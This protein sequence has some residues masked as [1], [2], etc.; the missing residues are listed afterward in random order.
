VRD[1]QARKTEKRSDSVSSEGRGGQN[2]GVGGRAASSATSIPGS[3]GDL[4]GKRGRVKGKLDQYGDTLRKKKWT[5]GGGI[6]K[7]CPR[8]LTD[9][10]VAREKDW[11]G[12]GTKRGR[13]FLMRWDQIG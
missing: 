1:R 7:T 13:D 8:V 12:G 3:G 2:I 6:T 4:R 5:L 10:S 9:L 11:G